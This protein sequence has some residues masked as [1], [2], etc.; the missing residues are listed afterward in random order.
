VRAASQRGIT[1]IYITKVS[2]GEARQ[3]T[4]DK[5]TIS[6]LAW[7]SEKQLVFTSNRAGGNMLWSISASGGAPELIA[8]AGRSVSRVSAANRLGR[9]VFE[10][11]FRNTNIWRVDLSRPGAPAERLISTTRRNDSPKY[12]PDGKSIVF[13]S[14]R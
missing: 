12:S 7:I 14:D 13:G 1:D 4:F 9:L 6:G 11:T 5:K 10:E 3:V 8:I 2:G